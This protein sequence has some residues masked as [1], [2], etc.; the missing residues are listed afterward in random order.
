MS[1]SRPGKST[2]DR[3]SVVREASLLGEAEGFQGGG[4]K[5]YT[6]AR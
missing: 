2:A 4:Q 3:G 1:S 5:L 6:L